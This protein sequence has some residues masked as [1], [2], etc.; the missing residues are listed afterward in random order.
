MTSFNSSNRFP[1]KSRLTPLSPVMFPPGRA[2]TCD[3]SSPNRITA[4]NRHDGYR[5][6][7]LLERNSTDGAIGN[8]HI[9]LESDQL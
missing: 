9:R 7:G 1:L 5:R 2:K 8:D 6:G 3:E 4:T